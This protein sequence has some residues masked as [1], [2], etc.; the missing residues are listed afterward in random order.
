MAERTSH[1]PGTF[2]W[3]DLATSDQ[4]AAKAFYR[5]LF[6]WE[7]EDMPMGDGAVYTMARIGGL[8]VGAIGPLQD[9]T[10]PPHWN[11]YVSVEDADAAAARARNAGAT[12]L[13][14]AFDVFDSGRMAVIQDP[15]GA[16]LNV[17][18]AGQHIGA[19]LVN[20]P[21]AL[22]W[23]DLVTPDPQ[24]SAG[25]YREL[26]GWR[27]EETEGAGGQYWSI[28]NGDRLNG[29]L[30]PAQGGQPPFWNAYFAVEDL[31]AALGT[32]RE[33][34]GSV[35]VEPMQVPAGRF[36]LVSDP[37]GAHFSLFTGELDP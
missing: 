27:V 29:G 20:A 21:G 23:N 11:C 26:F 35:V 19:Q 17:W 4:E 5:S 15:Q 33:Q 30:L 3:V 32:V 16:V 31:D 18:Q 25:F 12:V 10:Q 36:T 9:P 2:S 24:A 37:Q 13:A 6:S 34:G 14:D 28:F 22:S 8:Y 1:P 7:L